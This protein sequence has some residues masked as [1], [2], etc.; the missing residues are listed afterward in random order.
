MRR[1]NDLNLQ[2]KFGNLAAYHIPAANLT[3][4]SN[5]SAKDAADSVNVF[6]LVLNSYFNAGLSYLPD[7]Y[8]AYSDGRERPEV[9][10]D[11][12]DRLAG[13]P[14]ALCGADG[15]VSSP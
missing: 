7:C 8:Y 12:T 3:T 14:S 15:Y 2:M 10:A 13:Q 6:R 4:A 11:I 1:W 9:F 5:V